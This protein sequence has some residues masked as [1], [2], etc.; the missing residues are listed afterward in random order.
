MKKIEN[1]LLP[2]TSN[3]YAAITK[4]DNNAAHIVL[5]I[6]NARKLLG[7]ITDGD[8]RRGILR[9]IPLSESVI[10]IMNARPVVASVSE[11]SDLIYARM[12]SNKIR[13]MPLLNQYGIVC[14]IEVLEDIVN[15]N[16]KDNIVVLMAGGASTRLRPL[17]NDCPKPLLPIGGKPILETT[18]E[19]LIECGFYQFYISINYLGN[20]IKSYFGD[21]SRWGIS[22]QYLQESHQ[23]GTAGS[24]SFLPKNMQLP[25]IV[26]N[27]DLLTKVDFNQLI[28]FHKEQNASATMG[29]RE[30]DHTVPYGVCKLENNFIVDIIEKPTYKFFINAGVYV[31]EPQILGLI[32]HN[33]YFDM[34]ALFSLLIKLKHRA[35]AFPIREYWIDIGQHSDYERAHL[36]Y[37][38]VFDKASI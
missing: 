19:G 29:V 2:Q 11:S 5:V 33:A 15:Y 1:L 24:L 8:V 4:L 31:L 36:E 26:M 27:S 18:L 6:D 21:G 28:S 13:Q 9:G 20:Q 22:I 38:Y 25:L 37:D 32:P 14:G 3:I 10:K 23:M 16:K 17:T 7:T 35:A 34:P 30:F 12:R